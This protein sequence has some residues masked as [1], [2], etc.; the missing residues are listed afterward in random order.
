MKAL[1]FDDI[2]LVPRYNNIASRKDV[3]TSVQFGAE[4]LR[5]PVFSSNM[6]TVTGVTMALKMRELGGLGFLHRFSS[7]EDNVKD[8]VGC[9]KA[10][11]LT[12]KL[13]EIVTLGLSG[14]R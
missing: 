12:I 4:L 13:D 8:F 14:G 10:D 6:D 2:T 9:F 7:I 1:S 5:I 3:D 11:T